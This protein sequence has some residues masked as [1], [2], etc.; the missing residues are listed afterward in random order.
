MSVGTLPVTAPVLLD[1]V[2]E[3]SIHRRVATVWA[4]LIFN[5]LAYSTQPTVFPISHR[6]GEVLTQGALGAAVVLALTVNRRLVVRPNVLLTLASILCCSSLAISLRGEVSHI[7]SDFRALRLIVF[8][9]VLWLLTPWWGRRDLMLPRLYVRCLIVILA[10]T[11]VGFLLSP[12]TAMAFGRYSGAL[13]PIPPTQVAH[14]AAEVAGL[15]AVMWLAG[16]MRPR[17]AAVV[18]GAALIILVLTHTRTALIALLVAVCVASISL[19]AWKRRVR[20]VLIGGLIVLLV[21]GLALL[22]VLATWFTRGESSQELTDLSGRTVVWSALVHAPRTE[23]QVIFGFGMSNNG[24]DG[25]PIDN[26]WLAVYQDQGLFGD[27]LCGLMLL[28]L[29]IL[30]AMRPRSPARAMAIFILVYCTIASFTETGLGEPSTYMLD[31][32]VAASLLSADV[33]AL[34]PRRRKDDQLQLAGSP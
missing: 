29:L 5:V 32:T 9:F 27:V 17:N 10:S 11:V 24:F 3:R 33:F 21:V 14:Y 1:E 12:H 15:T 23:A 31:L 16:I 4:L 18:F 19:F 20:R 7:G 6:I 28:C 13:W 8:V 34:V 30:A 2:E 22:P 26:S 25:L